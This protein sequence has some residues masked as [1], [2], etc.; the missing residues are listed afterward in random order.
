M[1]ERPPR[2]YGEPALLGVGGPTKTRA[3]TRGPI[4][5]LAG[6]AWSRREKPGN[7]APERLTGRRSEQ[8]GAGGV[9]QQEGPGSRDVG[10]RSKPTG[11]TFPPPRA[12]RREAWMML[13]IDLWGAAWSWAIMFDIFCFKVA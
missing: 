9:V 12:G 10:L 2:A 5:G 8:N 4:D 6:D 7:G 11:A 13:F 3:G 1:A